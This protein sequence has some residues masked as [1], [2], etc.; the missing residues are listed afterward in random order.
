MK[1]LL[2]AFCLLIVSCAKTP[3]GL[4][5]STYHLRESMFQENDDQMVRGEVQRYL[6]GAVTVEERSQKIGQYYHVTWK[7]S[8]QLTAG[9]AGKTEVVFEYLQAA[10]GSKVKRIVQR[11]QSPAHA[12]AYFTIAGKDYAKNGRVL[13]WRVSVHNNG[14]TLGSKQSYLWR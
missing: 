4:T 14:E 7:Q 8:D 11:A 10:S 2:A 12:D 3:Q 6:H 5:V 13:A 1:Y 9:L